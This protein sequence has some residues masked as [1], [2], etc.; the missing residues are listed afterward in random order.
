M[1]KSVGFRWGIPPAVRCFLQTLWNWNGVVRF[2]SQEVWFDKGFVIWHFLNY[3]L[4]QIMSLWSL[5]IGVGIFFTTTELLDRTRI[6]KSNA[7]WFKQKIYTKMYRRPDFWMKQNAPQEGLIK[8]MRHRPEFLTKS[9]WALCPI[10][11]V[12]NLFSQITA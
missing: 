6:F 3:C 5:S 11:I 10:D 4:I 9:Y 8:K 12:C 1:S 7:S 2:V